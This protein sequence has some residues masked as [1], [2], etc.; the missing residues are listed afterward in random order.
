[1]GERGHGSVGAWGRGST[2]CSYSKRTTTTQ[3]HGASSCWLPA[4]SQK[5]GTI[6][7][8]PR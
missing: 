6:S 3:R 5:P 4:A 2:S 1:M 8:N 7:H